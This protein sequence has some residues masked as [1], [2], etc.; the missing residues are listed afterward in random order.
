MK[1]IDNVTWRLPPPPTT[2]IEA[3]EA[4]GSLGWLIQKLSAAYLAREFAV[5][6]H[7]GPERFDDDV[8]TAG[9]QGRI[10]AERFRFQ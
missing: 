7:F 10:I 6:E 8:E 2:M 9:E 4:I 1:N 5:P 3:Y